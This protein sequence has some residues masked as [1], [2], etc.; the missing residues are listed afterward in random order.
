MNE[1]PVTASLEARLTPEAIHTLRTVKKI[2]ASPDVRLHALYAHFFIGYSQRKVAVIFGKNVSTISRWVHQFE[3]EGT[4][5]KKDREEVFRKF[6]PE[7][8]EWLYQYYLKNPTNYLDEAAAE[9]EKEWGLTISMSYVW[10]IIHSKGLTRKVHMANDCCS[11]CFV[12]F[13]C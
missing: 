13:T 5:S 12:Y 6:T 8:H 9:F 4:L 10:T 7:Q 11:I 3:E 1:E 2:H